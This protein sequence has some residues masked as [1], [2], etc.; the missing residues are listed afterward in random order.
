KPRQNRGSLNLRNTFLI[1]LILIAGL[2]ASAQESNEPEKSFDES[3]KEALA[4]NPEDVTFTIRLVDGKTQFYQGEII[5]VELLFSSSTPGRYE[6][7]TREY[8][9]SGRLFNESFHVDPEDGAVDPLYD[10]F[11]SG[12]PCGFACGGGSSGPKVLEEKSCS[13]VL[14]INEWL[15]F[16]KPG[17]CRLYAESCRV[18]DTKDRGKDGVTRTHLPITSDITQLQ[19]LPADPE[20]SQEKLK[21][22]IRVLDAEPVTYEQL[23][24]KHRWVQ[25]EHDKALRFLEDQGA[26]RKQAARTLRFLGTEQATVELIK[27]F[28]GVDEFNGYDAEYGLGLLGSPH[29]SF[30]VKEMEKYLESPGHPVSRKFLMILSLSAF[31]L[32]PRHPKPTSGPDEE[33]NAKRWRE[34]FENEKLSYREIETQYLGRLV[35][36]IPNKDG[37]AKAI[38]LAAVVEVAR[39]TPEKQQAEKI[40]D[41]LKTLPSEIA[42]IFHTLPDLTQDILLSSYS[43]YLKHPAMI[44][45]LQDIYENPPQTDRYRREAALSLLYQISPEE[46]RKI[47]LE[48]I[49]SSHPCV[50]IHILELLPEETLPGIDEVIVDNLNNWQSGEP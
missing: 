43:R 48:E 13:F 36:A 33:E 40:A 26:K 7:E 39:E 47:I 46:G 44:P 1:S 25:E 15:R 9:R 37:Q 18:W 49:N 19:I 17:T 10:Y 3:Y 38:S 22:A 12:Y 45:V 11:Y 31:Y 5:R 32:G 14:Q 34:Y 28:N 23:V 41:Y 27:R 2:A 24:G 21:E 6:A 50:R 35:A 16:D 8:D 42:P 20:W 29:Q 4:K 30:V